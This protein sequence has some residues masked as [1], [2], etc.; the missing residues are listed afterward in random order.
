MARN[1]AAVTTV[2]KAPIVPF[3]MVEDAAP[4]KISAGVRTY[5]VPNGIRQSQSQW[6]WKG[7][8]EHQR[9]NKRKTYRVDHVG[10]AILQYHIGRHDHRVVD[11][12]IVALDSHC[13]RRAR[14]GCKDTPVHQIR[15]VAGEVWYNMACKQARSRG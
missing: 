5:Y 11:V 15:Q 1:S 6:K 9:V 8:G 13:D 7:D 14:L 4:V 2:A 10:D 3:C 12:I